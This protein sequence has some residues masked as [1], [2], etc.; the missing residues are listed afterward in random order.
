MKEKK[1]EQ[2]IFFQKQKDRQDGC[3]IYAINN[4]ME[5]VALN[6]DKF[7]KYCYEFD[8]LVACKG[9]REF[10]FIASDNN[11]ITFILTK[12]DVATTYYAPYS[13]KSV[14][15]ILDASNKFLVFSAEHIWC[16]RKHGGVWYYLDSMRKSPSKLN[17]KELS[18]KFGYIV[19]K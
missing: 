15:D 11:I 2:Q 4:L 5:R 1:E 6:E 16:C 14:E 17:I 3:R 18:P 8:K 13:C 7:D 10:F 9:T 19:V 12:F